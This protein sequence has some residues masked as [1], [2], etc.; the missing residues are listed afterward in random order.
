MIIQLQSLNLKSELQLLPV[1]GMGKFHAVHSLA[2][3]F[4]PNQVSFFDIK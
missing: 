3:S 4:N 2:L 1:S